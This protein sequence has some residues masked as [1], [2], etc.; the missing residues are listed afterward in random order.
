MLRACPGMTES[1]L[2]QQERLFAAAFDMPVPDRYDLEILRRGL[3]EGGIDTDSV[4]AV[5]LLVASRAADLGREVMLPKET[6]ALPPNRKKQLLDSIEP[7]FER[8]LA[9]E[10]DTSAIDARFDHTPVVEA[11]NLALATA[12]RRSAALLVLRGRALGRVYRI[13]SG[14][15]LM[16][17]AATA[18]IVLEDDGMSRYHA[19]VTREDE[20]HH[21][22]DLGS[23]NGV[24]VN[25]FK[26]TRHTL[27]EGDRIQLGAAT[28]LKFVYQDDIEEQFQQELYKSVTV[29]PLTGIYNRRHFIDRLRSECAYARRNGAPVSVLVIDIDHFKNI[30]DTWGHLAG[31]AVLKAVVGTISGTLRQED[32]FGRFGGDELCVILR[33]IEAQNALKAGSRLVELVRSL[34]IAHGDQTLK[35]TVSIGASTSKMG[36]LDTPQE[37]I[38]IADQALYRAKDQGRDCCVHAAD[39]RGA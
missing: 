14:R 12:S 36:V 27:E 31:D 28:L 32:V 4:H 2:K 25:G 16:G 38:D 17:R 30:N 33:G 11:R 23:R 9:S 20:T 8:Q 13:D 6:E 18:D 1:L 29:D 37:M 19:V 10:P 35:A 21:I 24:I 26:I 34:K 15:A 3:V 22:E 7:A 5:L 39:L